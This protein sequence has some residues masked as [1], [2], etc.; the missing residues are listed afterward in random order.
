MKGIKW[1]NLFKHYII[2]EKYGEVIIKMQFVGF[3]YCVNDD[4]KVD[5]EIFKA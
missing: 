1:K 2:K 5:L 3:F 4:K